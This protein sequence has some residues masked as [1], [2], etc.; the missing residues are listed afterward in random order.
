MPSCDSQNTITALRQVAFRADKHFLNASKF[1]A[2]KL[3]NLFD[4]IVACRVRALNISY[5]EFKN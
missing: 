4:A 1:H 2:L 3:C 5:G